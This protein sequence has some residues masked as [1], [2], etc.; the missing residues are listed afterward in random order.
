MRPTVQR[1]LDSITA[2]A[3]VRNGRLDILAANTLG[4][5]LY[6]PVFDDPSGTPNM[7]R[8][9]FLNRR[10]GDFFDNW[11]N[12]ANDAV[13]HL[14]APRPAA[15]PMTSG[16]QN[17][18]AS[19]QPAATSSAVRWAAHN[20][21]FHRTGAKTLHHPVVGDLTLDYEALD[22]AGDSGQ[23]ILVYSAEPGSRSQEALDLL[24]SWASTPASA[25]VDDD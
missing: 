18:S 14:R 5:A 11:E 24:A 2:P 3:Y 16:C 19:C 13:A 10:A 6:S 25:R 23:R 20:V 15:T 12:I 8:F 1:I 7:A 21:K 17:S 22:L 9:I 4:A